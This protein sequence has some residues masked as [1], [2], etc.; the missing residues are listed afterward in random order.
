[1]RRIFSFSFLLISVIGKVQIFNPES[2]K[3]A[4]GASTDGEIVASLANFGHINY[5]DTIVS[6]DMRVYNFFLYI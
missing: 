3:E 6:H 2:L 1:M 4:V 5:G